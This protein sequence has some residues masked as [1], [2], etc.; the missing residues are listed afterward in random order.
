MKR[1]GIQL[2]HSFATALL[3]CLGVLLPLHAAVLGA[4]AKQPLRVLYVGGDADVLGGPGPERAADFTSFLAQNF[5]EVKSIAGAD[6]KPELAANFDVIVKDAPISIVL[7]PTFRK[8]MVLVGSN[9]LAG[10]DRTGTKIK[11]L[12]ECLREKLYDIKLDHPIFQGP[13]PVKPTLVQETN[14]YTGE[15]ADMWKVHEKTQDPGL[16]TAVEQF[17]DAADSEVISGGINL[18]GDHG[19]ALV[20]EANLFLWGP[21]GSP[22][23]M[24]EEARRAFVNTIVYMKHFDGAQQTIWRGLDGRQELQMVLATKDLHTMLSPE[25]AYQNFLPELLGKYGAAIEKYRAYYTPDLPYVRQPHGN[26][27][28]EVDPDAKSLGIS[29]NAPLLL[30]KSVQLLADPAQSGRAVRLL[31]RY[32]GLHFATPEE[33]QIWLVANKEKLYFSDSYDYRFFTGPAGPAP[34]ARSIETAIRHMDLANPSDV[35]PVSVGATVATYY[36]SKEGNFSKKG[37]LIT[38]IVRLNIADGWHVYAKVPEDAPYKPV[39]L[40]AELP[41]GFR[42]SGD[43]TTPHASPGDVPGLTEYR[44]DAVFLR[45]F[46]ATSAASKALINGTVHVQACNTEKCLPAASGTFNVPLTVYEN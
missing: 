30:E 27:W 18:K 22:R 45:Q 37:A 29:N 15:T 41:K 8:P 31:E 14:P 16:V 5:I 25:R 34:T 3:L 20:R 1:N 44:G 11:L 4:N 46:Y 42:W 10:I 6:F 9:G 40:Q 7:P 12:C 32:T 35:S 19:V 28:F 2:T 36:Y 21:I 17:L 39:T 24:T 33:W 38:L 26:I 43:W 13:L 23:T